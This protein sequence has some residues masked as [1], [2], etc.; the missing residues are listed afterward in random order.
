MEEPQRRVL[1][2]LLAQTND[3]QGE[4]TTERALRTVVCAHA[5]VDPDTFAE[6]AFDLAQRGAIEY[7]DGRYLPAPSA[8][9]SSR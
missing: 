9:R 4:W 8:E 2:A 1:N 6:A 5:G 3:A 7:D